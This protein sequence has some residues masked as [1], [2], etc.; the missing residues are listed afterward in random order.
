M[1]PDDMLYQ[2]GPLLMGLVF[3]VATLLCLWTRNLLFFVKLRGQDAFVKK[4]NSD[5]S[6]SHLLHETR[7]L[8]DGR[9]T[10][11]YPSLLNTSITL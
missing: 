8:V 11:R 6:G 7:I 1:R 4:F 9:I 10:R 5:D 3:S 2:Y